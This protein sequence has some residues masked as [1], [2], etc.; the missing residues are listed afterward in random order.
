M[1]RPAIDPTSLAELDKKQIRVI[2][3]RQVALEARQK[4]KERLHRLESENSNLKNKA[5]NLERE[6]TSL[7]LQ[8]ESLKESLQQGLGHDRREQSWNGDVS[9]ESVIAP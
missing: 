5:T 4:A 7:K 1:K 2:R 6:N 3:N 9:L 8:I